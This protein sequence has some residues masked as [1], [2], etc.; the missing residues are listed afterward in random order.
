MKLYYDQDAD[1]SHLTGKTVAVLGY[2]SQ[3]HAHSQNLN[4]SGVN[5]IVGL[6][7]QSASWAKA[8]AAGLRVAEPADAAEMADIIMIL[9]PDQ[10]QAEVYERYVKPHLY[11]GKSLVFAH[12]FN[13][14]FN[15]IVPPADV[16]VCSWWRRRDPDTSC[17]ASTPRAS[18]CLA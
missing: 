15:Q 2:G 1:L 14:H 3:G 5:V 11:P 9:L 4:D 13:V 6:R 16:D 8:Q 10:S 18:A 17:A 12:G 7:K